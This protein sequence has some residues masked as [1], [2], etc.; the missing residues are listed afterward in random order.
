MKIV[1][2]VKGFTIIETFD[3]NVLPYRYFEPPSHHLAKKFGLFSCTGGQIKLHFTICRSAFVC[4]ENIS[5][6]GLYFV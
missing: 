3:L 5:I 2:A 1:N 4:G 6:E